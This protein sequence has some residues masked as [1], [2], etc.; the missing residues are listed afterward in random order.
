MTRLDQAQSQ[1]SASAE[2]TSPDASF[3]LV[4]DLL[5]KRDSRNVAPECLKQ[6][7]LDARVPGIQVRAPGGE[8]GGTGWCPWCIDV[9]AVVLP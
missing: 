5:Q 2:F 1:E 3:K 7:V 9:R 4:W 8:I 6:C